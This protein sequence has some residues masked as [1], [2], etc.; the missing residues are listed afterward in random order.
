PIVVAVALILGWWGISMTRSLSTPDGSFRTPVADGEEGMT[1]LQ[2]DSEPAKTP[3][4]AVKPV[5]NVKPTENVKPAAPFEFQS[6]LNTYAQLKA[7]V[8]PSEEEKAARESL[9]KNPNLLRSIGS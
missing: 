8:L 7:K 1:A 5:E 3:A 2:I 6:E 4:A 9:L